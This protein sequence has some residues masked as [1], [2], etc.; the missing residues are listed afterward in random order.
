LPDPPQTTTLDPEI[1]LEAGDKTTKTETPAED[2][3]HQ[4]YTITQ[5]AKTIEA[6]EAEKANADILRT[7]LPSQ[8]PTCTG[9]QQDPTQTEL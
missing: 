4:A 9:T 7:P 6:E 3:A 1:L 5:Q 8:G 2:T